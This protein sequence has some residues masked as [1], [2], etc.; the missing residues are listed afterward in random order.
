MILSWSANAFQHMTTTWPITCRADASMNSSPRLNHRAS[1]RLAAIHRAWESR[2]SWFICLHWAGPS[3]GTRRE[4]GANELCLGLLSY[5]CSE[6]GGSGLLPFLPDL[7]AGAS[8]YFSQLGRGRARH[9]WGSRGA[10]A[11]INPECHGPYD[12]RFPR[13][14]NS[15]APKAL[16]T[17]DG[18]TDRSSRI[19]TD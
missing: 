12:W 14:C 10:R 16:E 13:Y 3:E 9:S 8:F 11:I 4:V 5:V 2:E 18:V 15:G 19:T 6:S 17:C 7:G 1:W